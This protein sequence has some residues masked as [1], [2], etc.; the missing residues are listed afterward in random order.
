M[1]EGV[2]FPSPPRRNMA[3]GCQKRQWRSDVVLIISIDLALAAA[4][5]AAAAAASCV[6]L[7][8]GIA[9]ALLSRGANDDRIMT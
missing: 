4:A 2:Q 6:L 1:A 9:R 8:F 7:S 5:F 3:D